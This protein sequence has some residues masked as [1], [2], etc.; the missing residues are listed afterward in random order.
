MEK[1][2]R[3]AFMDKQSAAAYLGID[4]KF[5]A[6]QIKTGAGPTYIRPSPKIMLFRRNDLDAWRNS[7]Q[8]CEPA[9]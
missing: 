8:V 9:R 2:T 1:A 7:W 6:N 3:T 5:L 4:L